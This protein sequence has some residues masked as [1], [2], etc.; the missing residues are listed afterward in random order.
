MSF[1]VDIPQRYV[2]TDGVTITGRGSKTDPLLATTPMVF[3]SSTNYS[4]FEDDGT[5]V[6]HGD[7]TVWQDVDFPI[8]IRTTGA[9][10]PTLVALQGN[11]LAPQW[12]VNDFSN[13]EGQEL[14]HGWKE[15]SPIYWHVHLITNGADTTIRY[16]RWEIEWVWANLGAQLSSTITTDS[17]DIAIPANTPTKTH[18]LQ[19]ISSY[20]LVGGH[21]GGHIY[22]RLRR[23]ASTGAAPT[24][25]P[26][27][28]MLQI[29]LEID[30]IGS[31]TIANK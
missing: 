9:N 2:Y 8:I 7:A 14:I 17:G 10:I 3:G 31:R 15:G 30:T 18:I 27:C 20:T 21:I 4:E 28:S 24:N 11:V 5:L 13:C 26:W 25:N 23:I 19:S 6:A 29:H 12:A 22:A 1:K 16:L